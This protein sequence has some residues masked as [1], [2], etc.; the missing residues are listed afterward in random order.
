[1]PAPP[2]LGVG[3]GFRGGEGSNGSSDGSILGSV[4]HGGRV[5][6]PGFNFTVAV[7]VVVNADRLVVVGHLV[8]VRSAA[9]L[10]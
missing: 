6:E 4:I 9:V 7:D 3:V 10:V 1:L 5:E 2:L 8:E